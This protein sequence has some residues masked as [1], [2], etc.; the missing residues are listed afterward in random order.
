MLGFPGVP[1]LRRSAPHFQC[2]VCWFTQSESPTIKDFLLASFY[3][4]TAGSSRNCSV[5]TDQSGMPANEDCAIWT[6]R[7]VQNL[8]YVK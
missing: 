1:H 8:V 3:L 6:V 4:R 5:T 7:T 2:S